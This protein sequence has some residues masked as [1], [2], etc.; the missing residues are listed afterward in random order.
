MDQWEIVHDNAEFISVTSESSSSI[1]D[2]KDE[3]EANRILSQPIQITPSKTTT[4]ILIPLVK[5]TTLYAAKKLFTSKTFVMQ[6][7]IFAL[8]YVGHYDWRISVMVTVVNVLLVTN[9]VYSLM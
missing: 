7:S 8:H 2:E 6:A 1:D 3:I 9:K 4:G 5:K